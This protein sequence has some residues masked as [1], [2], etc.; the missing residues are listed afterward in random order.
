MV[1]YLY[2]LGIRAPFVDKWLFPA[3]LCPATMAP[4]PPKP[5][6]TEPAAAAAPGD[7]SSS[8]SRSASSDTEWDTGQ[9][10][11]PPVLPPGQDMSA[12]AKLPR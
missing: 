3:T 7:E 1:A 11:T 5:D 2:D 6:R 4:P 12:C 9:G 8:S 10:S